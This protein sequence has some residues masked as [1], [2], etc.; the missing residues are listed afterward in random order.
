MKFL[1]INSVNEIPGMRPCKNCGKKFQSKYNAC[2]KC[3]T[4]YQPSELA[5]SV[6]EGK[7]LSKINK[8]KARDPLTPEMRIL[9]NQNEE[10]KKEV[11]LLENRIKELE[12]F[13]NYDLTYDFNF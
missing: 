10:L 2:N 12:K 6:I 3:G 9:W 5:K 4:P 1:K 11:Q 8:S 13:M 7:K